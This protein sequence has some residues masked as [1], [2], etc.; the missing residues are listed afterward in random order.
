MARIDFELDPDAVRQL[1][2]L[3]DE[4]LDRPAD[5]RDQWLA[6]L[7]PQFD[8]LKPHLRDLLSRAA[9]V[10]TADW[11]R[12]VPKLDLGTPAESSVG[13]AT[14]TR[15]E[16][17]GPYRLMRE[18]GHGGMGSVWLAQ[19]EG[20]LYNRP[21]ALKLPHVAP[22]A[23]LAERMAREREILET[24][25]HRHIARLFDAGLT[26]AAQPYLALEYIE[27][28]PID[29]YCAGGAS[30]P[31]L[32][33]PETL[34]LFLQIV[35]AVAYA[36]GKLVIH[37]DLKPSNVL[38]DAAGDAWLLDFGVAKMLG[39]DG[40]APSHL[41][42]VS[43]RA[44][45][46]DYASPEQI[47]GQPL[48]VASDVYSLGVI[49][50][51]LL[52]GTRPYRLSR[53]SRGALEDAI[54]Q[55]EPPPLPPALRGD[56]QTVVLKALRKDP[57]QRY[58][59]ANDFADD[60]T[61]YLE[62]RPV[63]AQPDTRGY[64]L[65]R[66]VARNR[67]AVS[68]SAAIAVALLA[69]TVVSAWQAHEARL[70]AD[71]ADAVK[72][73]IVSI[74]AD[75]S[76]YVSGESLS[77]TQLLE[78]ARTRL[79]AT[80]IADT[81]VRLELLNSLGESMLRLNDVKG[82]AAV[83]DEAV[84]LADA[85]EPRSPEAERA[86]VLHSESL[87]VDARTDGAST[88]IEHAIA[89]MRKEPARYG[90]TYVA[91]LLIRA[92]MFNADGRSVD[93]DRAAREALTQARLLPGTANVETVQALE[94]LSVANGYLH[95]DDVA[96]TSARE[97]YVMAQRLY[98]GNDSHPVYNSVREQYAITL[99]DQDRLAEGLEM[100]EASRAAAARLFGETSKITAAHDAAMVKHL[101]ADG[102]I[103]DALE[104]ARRSFEIMAPQYTRNV[105]SLAEIS[106]MRGNALLSAR[107]PASALPYTERAL[108]YLVRE[109]GPQ[110][111]LAFVHRLQRGREL[112]L[113]GRLDDA[114]RDLAW[115][116]EQY[117]KH[118]RSNM[119][120]PLYQL[121]LLRRLQGR[122]SAAIELQQRALGAL[123]V[124]PRSARAG[125]RIRVELGLA[126]WAAG[127]AAAARET[128]ASALEVF[129]TKFGARPPEFADAQSALGQMDLAAGAA[130]R[131]LPRFEEADVYWRQLDGDGRWAGESAYW[132]ARCHRVLQRPVEAAAA[133]LRAEQRLSGSSFPG[134]NQRLAEVLAWRR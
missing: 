120:M 14:G 39:A 82:A 58:A 116:V 3:L 16:L 115:V 9:E 37:R 125:A 8:A 10:E 134:D 22:Y 91:A 21:V 31:P 43:G 110:S 122:P 24:L 60:L 61:R 129:R 79:A 6:T 67:V 76:P 44:M 123:P 5:A 27:G 114:E 92:R 87:S 130:D 108:D 18:L 126:Q 26:A 112:A 1:N 119:S 128:I 63:R 104:Y 7:G 13:T 88:E 84:S 62:Q 75:A 36:H 70:Q 77:A 97:G 54:V 106:S 57:A 25:E 94:A 64:R 132:L 131:A 53:D 118:G 12:A 52:A 66:F 105:P 127:D 68:G 45:T 35:D 49:L 86:H 71:R 15:G 99:V 72:E 98:A 50:Y 107:R 80:R 124:G 41:T 83:L 113:L 133:A 109:V 48:G 42:E 32:A 47:L 51:E 95:N 2:A 69:G 89:T 11:L 102:R 85:S 46:P 34:R 29:A 96:F 33:V 93:A 74:F 103:A 117:P 78:Q 17:I 4:A 56:L 101:I 59:T 23:G 121:G 20:S 73:F 38:V 28:V 19:R 40:G 111:E 81:H 100:M 65:R 30:R 55:A 90:R